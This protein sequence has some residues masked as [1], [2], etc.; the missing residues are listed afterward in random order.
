[1][2]TRTHILKSQTITVS[3]SV[4]RCVYM[5]IFIE[6]VF[7]TDVFSCL[8]HVSV[9]LYNRRQSLLFHLLFM[10]YLCTVGLFLK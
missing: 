7:V 10:D 2:K 3:A 9:I 4:C 5:N 1:M 8:R 6:E